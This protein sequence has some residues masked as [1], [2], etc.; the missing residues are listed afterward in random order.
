[1]RVLYIEL[2]SASFLHLGHLIELWLWLKQLQNSC[3][4]GPVASPME[5]LLVE[6]KS[7]YKIF[8]NNI[9]IHRKHCESIKCHIYP[10]SCGFFGWVIIEC[11]VI[12][13]HYFLIKFNTNLKIIKVFYFP[14][15][16]P[17]FSYLIR[18]RSS[19]IP[20]LCHLAVRAR[21]RKPSNP[22]FVS[23]FFFL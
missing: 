8:G 10:R 21:L 7:F 22:D 12:L 9:Y 3:G 11:L 23:N 18:L 2:P 1:M 4:C 15:I 17:R 19:S 5:W 13:L 14:Y 6:L 20:C 16:F